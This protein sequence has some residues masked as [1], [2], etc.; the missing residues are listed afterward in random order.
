MRGDC[1]ADCVSWPESAAFRRPRSLNMIQ[2]LKVRP[3]AWRARLP[4]L[5]SNPVP[6]AQWQ[7]ETP[8]AEVIGASVQAHRCRVA[9]AVQ[10]TASS[11]C[12]AIED[13]SNGCTAERFAA[14]RGFV[15]LRSSL[16]H[17][18]AAGCAA[19]SLRP[20][21]ARRSTGSALRRNDFEPAHSRQPQIDD[22]QSGI[23]TAESRDM[24]RHA[25]RIRQHSHGAGG[26]QSERQPLHDQTSGYGG[27]PGVL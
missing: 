23:R 6:S 18:P 27:D 25:D 17:C 20:R 22:R 15:T 16:H 3:G 13:G 5:I 10:V 2:N 7:N 1:F 8:V 9:T 12:P 24:H 19:S 11:I 4:C 14:T 26:R 21:F